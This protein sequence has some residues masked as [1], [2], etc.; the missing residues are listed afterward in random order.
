MRPNKAEVQ[1]LNL[2][3]NRF[4]DLYD[5]AMQDSFWKKGKNF[6]FTK[7]RDSFSIYTELLNYEPLKWVIQELKEKRPPMESEIGSELFKLLEMG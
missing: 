6:R 3:Y 4:Y 5:L 1:F 7:I 2:A